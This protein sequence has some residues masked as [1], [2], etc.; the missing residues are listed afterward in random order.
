M[1]AVYLGKFGIFAYSSF[2][3]ANFTMGIHV[4]NLQKMVVPSIRNQPELKILV[5]P[6]LLDRVVGFSDKMEILPPKETIV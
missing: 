1:S 6:Y 5:L 4:H 3:V 2:E